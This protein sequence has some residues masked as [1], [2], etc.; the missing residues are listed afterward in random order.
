MTR[1]ELLAVAVR[2]FH[3]Y[4]YGQHFKVTTDHG[5]L[6]WL[7]NFRNPKEARRNRRRMQS[8]SRLRKAKERNVKWTVKSI[9]VQQPR[10]LGVTMF[11]GPGRKTPTH[12]LTNAELQQAQLPDQCFGSII[13]LKEK[14]T[15]CPVLLPLDLLI[16]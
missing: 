11:T 13:E 7:M 14:D 6:K 15:E 3:H 8:L 16:R 2:H 1:K 4:L 9:V 10:E 12:A 5:V